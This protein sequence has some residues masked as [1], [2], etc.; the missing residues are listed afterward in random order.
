MA[1]T[2]HPIYTTLVTASDDATLKVWEWESGEL[3][4]TLKGHTKS[5]TDCDF[6]S[7]GKTLGEFSLS[8][9]QF[10]S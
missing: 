7:K 10:P 1:V 2:F 6:D 3:E 8:S 5:V 4:K 9:S